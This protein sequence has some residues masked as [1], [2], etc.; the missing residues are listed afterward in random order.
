MFHFFT[1]QDRQ[2][3][4]ERAV[5]VKY[6]KGKQ[7]LAEGEDPGGI[8]LIRA[9]SV[10]VERGGTGERVLIARLGPGQIFGEISFV[11][12][13][14]ASAA[15]IAEDEVAIDFISNGSLEALFSES[16]QLAVRLY[17]S[18]ALVLAGRLRETDARLAA[19]KGPG[20]SS[21]Q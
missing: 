8:H 5:R 12:K 6:A 1:E 14:G 13:S 3:L 21:G 17:R 15:V 7:I 11:D 18:V 20:E 10:R 4:M 2:R 16:P 19:K 9:G